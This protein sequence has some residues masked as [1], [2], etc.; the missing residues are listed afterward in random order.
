[1]DH[2]TIIQSGNSAE[3]PFGS[4]TRSFPDSQLGRVA[5]GCALAVMLLGL[6]V[7]IGWL[8]GIEP[9]KRL[10]PQLTTM[11]FNTALGF[12]LAGAA[13]YLRGKP[14]LRLGL[15]GGVGLL[16]A[17]TLGQEVAGVDF[18]IDQL[19][20]RAAAMA[21]QAPG[22]MSPATAV[23]FLLSGA[24]LGLLGCRTAARWAEPLAIS[25]GTVGF[26]ALLGYACGTPN[27]YNIPGFVSVALHSAAGCVVL[28]AGMLC[29]VPGG[30][31]ALLLRTRGT[32]RLLWLSFGALTA[33]L[34]FLG[35]I[36]AS[37]LR[38]IRAGVDEQGAVGRPRSDAT[39]ELEVAVLGY[40]LGVRVF[41]AGDAASRERANAD[42]RDVAAS[43][44]EYERLVE[45]PRQRELTARFTAQWDTLRTLGESL[46]AAGTAAPDELAR[47]AALRLALVG[48]LDDEMQPESVAAYNTRQVETQGTLRN[49]ENFTLLLLVGGV[50]LALIISGGVIRA[51]IGGEEAQRES[52][53]RY[54]T[55]FDSI[56]EGFCVIEPLLDE[57]AQPM[58]FRYLE[59]NPAFE[60]LTGLQGAT[61]KTIREL[62][63]EIESS[64][65][66]FYGNVVTS[67]ES[68]RMVNEAKPLNR[69]FEVYAFRMGAP[70][71]PLV[72]VLFS[73]ITE[74]KRSEEALRESEERTRLATE[75]TGVG[76]WEW[77]VLTT[78]I[79]WNATMFSIFG[80]TPT[81]DGV[82]PYGAWRNAVLP[83]ELPEQ[84]AVLQDTVR[85]CGRN[86]RAFRIRRE[87]DGE[88]R[89]IEGV[90][91]VRTNAQGEVE[92]VVGTNLDVTARKQAEA[93]LI[94]SAELRTRTRL[95]AER[96]A[97]VE[98]ARLTLEEKAAELAL[99][100]KYKSE[101][102]ANMSHEL[103]TPLNSILIF[104]QQLAENKAGNLTGKQVEYSS[105]IQ[106]SG[107]DLLHLITDILDL[108]KI[109]SGTFSIDI[110][111]ISIISLRDNIDRNFRYVAEAKS[112][113][114]DVHMAEGLPA[115]LHSDPK[116]LQ[117][118]LKNLLSNAVK[119]TTHGKVEVRMDFATQG[120]SPDH[121]VLSKALQVISFAVED[122][123]IGIASEKQRLIFEAFQQADA[124][125]SRN[126]GGTGL[127]LAISRELA[128]LLGGE[129]TVTSVLGQGSTFTLYLAVHHS[130]SDAVRPTAV[131]LPPV[132]REIVGIA[133]AISHPYVPAAALHGRKVLVVDDDARNIFALVALLENHEMEVLT[134]TGGRQAIEMIQSTPDL[135]LV[136]MDIMM[137]EM[138]GYETMREI[139]KTPEFRTLPILALTAKAMTGDREKCLE[140]GASDYIA[141][142][143]DT[144]QLVALMLVW[145][146]P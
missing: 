141:K 54:R 128:L 44:A 130:G 91:I 145:L 104:S 19:F 132:P 51:V 129:I 136:L 117:Q 58:D 77:N 49:T 10:L 121:P 62:V 68:A 17:L 88:C 36:S 123:G 94:E 137:P 63:P 67:G 98:L 16:G 82:V 66:E 127:G 135:S 47:L 33:L 105:H 22:R 65:I 142:P 106:S 6:A 24:A 5:T 13:L 26:I 107:T 7:M 35:V 111:E 3:L 108:S 133:N 140:A 18:G 92:W 76:I 37:G 138:D 131:G 52:N 28:A 9:L 74:R 1:M 53:E 64:W 8:L 25:V 73:N 41:L 124:G 120:W 30:I 78:Q 115:T 103:R 61:G 84:E 40:G 96:N 32:G 80:V 100:S 14:A 112:L 11:K 29:A 31:V 55:L 134:A 56:D 45:T 72:G 50:V 20:V 38:S 89:H 97:E 85:R 90:E 83:E 143:V 113:P 2:P 57:R 146:S 12:L 101:F 48:F 95:L 75:A 34:I 114:F 23:C 109:E 99:T 15:A 42:A 86:T 93:S 69:W 116:R 126:Y 21:G 110:G 4:R 27:L 119:F 125:T 122:T 139:R 81:P 70:E 102:L 144:D 59:I 60:K 39:R 118:I 87:N 79:R 71:N 43:L 46:M